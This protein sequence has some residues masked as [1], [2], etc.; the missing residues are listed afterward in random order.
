MGQTS[1]SNDETPQVLLRTCS[2]GGSKIGGLGALF[3]T[4]FW[5]G[6]WAK[7]TL[8]PVWGTNVTMGFWPHLGYPILGVPPRWGIW[9]YPHSGGTPNLGILVG[10]TVKPGYGVWGQAPNPI[11][12]FHRISNEE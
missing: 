8:T 10:D 4:P 9:G 12:R 7:S 1:L 6:I 3:G 2:K 11:P 5:R